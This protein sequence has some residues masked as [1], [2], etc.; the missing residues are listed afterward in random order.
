MY[1]ATRYSLRNIGSVNI[2]WIGIWAFFMFVTGEDRTGHST[3]PIQGMGQMEQIRSS[4]AI[5][6][7]LKEANPK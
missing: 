7:V 4:I 5:L 3:V 6:N 1:L 2:T